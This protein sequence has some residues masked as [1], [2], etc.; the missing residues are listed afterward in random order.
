MRAGMM[1]PRGG[2]RAGRSRAGN[3]PRS[4]RDGLVNVDARAA[5]ADGVA[6]VLV[7]ASWR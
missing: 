7:C 5:L 3:A 6:D 1:E 4:G 2:R